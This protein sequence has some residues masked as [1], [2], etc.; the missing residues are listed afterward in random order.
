MFV[1]M[2]EKEGYIIQCAT[3]GFCKCE[4]CNFCFTESESRSW[5][6][7]WNYCSELGWRNS[8]CCKNCHTEW[9][10]KAFDYDVDNDT[11]AHPS[12]LPASPM[13]VM[14]CMRLMFPMFLISH[15]I[16][17]FLTQLK[18]LGFSILLTF[19][20]S[21]TK[22]VPMIMMLLVNIE[23]TKRLSRN[24]TRGSREACPAA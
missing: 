6:P 17:L 18:F 12:G 15:M 22:S 24:M 16:L 13:I 9:T 11:E 2:S 19:L 8:Y 4:I 23:T 14:W 20:M 21:L 1:L 7:V 3:G 5:E 10:N